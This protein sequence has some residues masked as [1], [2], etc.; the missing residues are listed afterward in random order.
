MEYVESQENL[1]IDSEVKF[2]VICVMGEYAMYIFVS[3]NTWTT[4]I[5][6]LV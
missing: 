2:I 1:W 3:T 4:H 5:H 6:T